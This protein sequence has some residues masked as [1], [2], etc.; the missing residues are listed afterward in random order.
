MFFPYAVPTPKRYVDAVGI[1][2]TRI[3]VCD[4]LGLP[5]IH[6][7]FWVHFVQHILLPSYIADSQ[8]QRP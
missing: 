1:F 5:D 7:N 8:T 3:R 6:L 2:R 4:W